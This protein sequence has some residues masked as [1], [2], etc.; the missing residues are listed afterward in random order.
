L[1]IKEGNGWNDVMAMQRTDMQMNAMT[2]RPAGSAAGEGGVVTIVEN[3]TKTFNFNGTLKANN[4]EKLMSDVER[5]GS[6]PSQRKIARD[7]RRVLNR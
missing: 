1:F 4:P 7:G 5:S 6:R 2:A 3:H